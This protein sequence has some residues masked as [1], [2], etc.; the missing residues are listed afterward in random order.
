MQRSVK[1]LNWRR[2]SDKL[3]TSG[4]PSEAQLAAIRDLGVTHVVNLGLHTHAKALKDEAASVRALGMTYIHIPVDFER[5]DEVDFKRFC[6]TINGLRDA[7]VHVHC[8]LNARVSA[9]FFRYRR[10]VLGV[11]ETQARAEMEMV[12]RPGGAWAAFV[13]D[14]GRANSPHEYAR[15]DYDPQESELP[16]VVEMA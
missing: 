3:T 12:W 13:G 10:D 9:F 16:A 5:P 4:Q 8:I 15:Q 2:L 11:D 6:A 7:T 1:V 14:P